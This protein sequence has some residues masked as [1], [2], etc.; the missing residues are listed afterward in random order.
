MKDYLQKAGKGWRI[1]CAI[2]CTFAAMLFLLFFVILCVQA[3]HQ[4][5]FN[6]DGMGFL[7]ALLIMAL[8][9]YFTVFL[10]WRLWSGSQSKNGITAMPTWFI[11]MFG[12]CFL[13]GS[14]I[15]AITGGSKITFVENLCI[16]SA[17]IYVGRNIARHK[18]PRK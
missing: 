17:M 9:C 14:A 10:A 18:N 7:A 6:S 8:L 2:A 12:V 13:V 5:L 15:V 4:N 16:A 11:Q 1:T 3:S